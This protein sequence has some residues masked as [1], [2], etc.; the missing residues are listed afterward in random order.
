MG[1]QEPSERIAPEYQR[2]DGLDAAKLVRIGGTV[3]DPRPLR[4]K[5]HDP[6]VLDALAIR[7][8]ETASLAVKKFMGYLQYR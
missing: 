6:A 3:L 5:R 8:Q 1:S 4:H 2:S 7:E